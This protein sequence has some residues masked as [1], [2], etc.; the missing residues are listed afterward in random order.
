MNAN[1]KYTRLVFVIFLFF[2]AP[3]VVKCDTYAL[4]PPFSASLLEQ[5][6]GDIRIKNPPKRDGH[7]NI[8]EEYLQ[9]IDLLETPGSPPLVEYGLMDRHMHT[10]IMA[11]VFT[12]NTSCI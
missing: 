1:Y 9:F 7:V 10:H 4:Y 2:K 12:T 3:A 11:C 6:R 8:R 5:M